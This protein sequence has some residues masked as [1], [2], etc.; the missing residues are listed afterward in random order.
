MMKLV[1]C[2]HGF[3]S[4]TPL[5]PSPYL[6]VAISSDQMELLNPTIQD[7]QTGSIIDQCTGAAAKKV[8]AKHRIDIV[9]G[10]INSYARVL[11]GPH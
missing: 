2:N 6:D 10:N 8:I 7:V 4:G 3:H 9:T 5:V 11:N 1:A